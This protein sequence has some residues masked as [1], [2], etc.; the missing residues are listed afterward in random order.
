[1]TALDR[2][3]RILRYVKETLVLVV[4][5]LFPP[6]DALGPRPAADAP[7]ERH[8]RLAPVLEYVRPGSG[9]PSAGP[10]GAV[11][12]PAGWRAPPR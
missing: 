10:D 5:A 9:G 11:T 3:I 1:M 4:Q 2:A 12:V 6:P 7:A 8:A